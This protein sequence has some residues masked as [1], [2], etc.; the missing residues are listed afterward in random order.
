MLNCWPSPGTIA[1]SMICSSIVA[2]NI[3]TPSRKNCSRSS[4]IGSNK[5]TGQ[6]I[7]LRVKLL[8]CGPIQHRSHFHLRGRRQINP[9][10]ATRE[11][12]FIWQNPGRRKLKYPQ[13][14][15]MKSFVFVAEP[16]SHNFWREDVQRS[17]GF[18]DP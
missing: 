15:D 13:K 2:P 14:C 17:Q 16:F 3:K 18:R 9:R 7:E 5:V 11:S 1:A 4:A 8:M 6:T 10:T 12:F